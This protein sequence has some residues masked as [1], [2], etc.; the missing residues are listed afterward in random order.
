MPAFRRFRRRPRRATRA[1]VLGVAAWVL[2]SGASAGAVEVPFAATGAEQP[3]PVPAGVTRIHVIAIGG[4]G[5][6]QGGFGAVATAD[7]SVVPGSTLYVNVGGSA[8]TAQGGFNG[9]G[10]ARGPDAGGG[11]GASDVRSLS[12]TAA[13]AQASLDSRLIAA[14]GGGGRGETGSELHELGA[15]VYWGGAGAEAGAQGGGCTGGS[16]ATCGGPGASTMGGSGGDRGGEQGQKGAGGKGALYVAAGGG[17]GGGLYGGGGGG[18]EASVPLSPAGCGAGGGGGS[19]GFA[20]SAVNRSVVINSA[21]VAP[22]VEFTYTVT[23]DPPVITGTDP[24]SPGSSAKPVVKGTVGGGAPTA[25]RV[26]AN[27]TCAGEPAASGSARRSS[28]GRGSRWRWRK[29]RRC[30]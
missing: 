8:T 1:G 3:W 9:G 20:A 24:A 25:I 14:A 21:G 27:A 28:P 15:N 17:G 30:G 5:G 4:A 7:L 6:L 16:T 18:G 22:A 29:A 23:P 12:R 26:F 10:D 19:S 2:L 13:D 11:G